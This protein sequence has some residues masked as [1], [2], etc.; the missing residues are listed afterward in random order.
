MPE[1]YRKEIDDL[2]ASQ[3]KEKVCPFDGLPCEHPESCDHVLSLQFGR[4]MVLDDPCPR[5]KS[6][7]K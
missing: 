3:N 4:D 6:R 2:I 1:D 7:R 5:A